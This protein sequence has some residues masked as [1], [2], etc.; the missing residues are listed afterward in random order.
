MNTGR[1]S[2]VPPRQRK[3]DVGALRLNPDRTDEA[4][5]NFKSTNNAVFVFLRLIFHVKRT[6]NGH[7]VLLKIKKWV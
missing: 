4:L 7:F 1:C 3:K 2:E 5:S 6:K